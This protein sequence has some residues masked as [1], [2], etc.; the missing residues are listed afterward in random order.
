MQLIDSKESFD[1][2]EILYI[3]TDEYIKEQLTHAFSL[4]RCR[5]VSVENIEALST[6]IK[7]QKYHIVLLNVA[8]LKNGL[9]LAREILS[10]NENQEIIFI[11]KSDDARILYNSIK[12]HISDYIFLPLE[13]K[14]ILEVIS[15]VAN[16]IFLKQKLQDHNSELEELIEKKTQE[17]FYKSFHDSL[18]GLQNHFALNEL[19]ARAEELSLILLNVDNFGDINNAYGFKVGDHMLQEIAKLLNIVK[20]SNAKL[21]RLN[22]DEFVYIIEKKL[23]KDSLIELLNSIEYFF[24]ETEVDLDDHIQ[25]RISFSIGVAQGRGGELLDQ[26]KIAI[27]ESREH[28]NRGSY[29][30]FDEHSCFIEKQKAN[31]YWIHKIKDSISTGNLFPYYQPIINNKTCKIEKYECLA[32]IDDLDTLI[33]PIRFMEAAKITGMLPHITRTIIQQSFEAFAK[34]EY[35]FSI[36]IT[37]EDLYT[38]YLEAFL[39]RNAKKYAIEPSRVVLEILEDITSLKEANTIKQLSSLREKGFKIA[40]DDFGSQSSNFSRLLEFSPD[41]LKIDGSFIKNLIDDEKSRII[42]E[43]IV[44][45]SHKSNIKVIAEYVHNQ[46]VQELVKAMGIDYSQGFFFGKP[47]HDLL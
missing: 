44:L 45:I 4:F 41:Y 37:S 42:C 3:D 35:E 21:F 24:N 12:L 8:A 13:S 47:E 18:T 39:L 10:I 31:V 43:A 5:V 38:E 26:A 16:K 2:L 40:I 29:S 32:R 9:A 19:L 23:A 27:M 14:H 25:T 11:S 22:S 33:P 28:N 46:E 17:L 6:N 20:P 7:E 34:N 1:I 30:F 36:N 15:K